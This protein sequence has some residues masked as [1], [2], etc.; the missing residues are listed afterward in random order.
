MLQLSIPVAVV[1]AVFPALTHHVWQV[2]LAGGMPAAMLLAVTAC[3]IAGIALRAAPA[4]GEPNVH[5]RQL[6]VILAVFFIGGGV[7]LTAAWPERFGIDQTLTGHQI[8][9]ATA[10]LTGGYLLVA[11]TRLT[12]RLRF[13]LLL[14]FIAMPQI[15]E[16]PAVLGLLVA[17]AIVRT[18]LLAIVRF[19]RSNRTA[20]AVSADDGLDSIQSALLPPAAGEH[21]MSTVNAALRLEGRGAAHITNRRSGDSTAKIHAGRTVAT[22]SGGWR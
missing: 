20:P 22:E 8:I 10:L 11:G 13:V 3:A 1:L 12:A 21:Q 19:R 18:L 6:D 16:R 15:T 9:A 17:G 14:P 2:L 7:W 4:S 5:D